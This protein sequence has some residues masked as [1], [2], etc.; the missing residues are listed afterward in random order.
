M[1]QML[2][3]RKKM[4]SSL[5]KH[6]NGS[7]GKAQLGRMMSKRASRRSHPPG[8]DVTPMPVADLAG[9]AHA[10]LVE[11]GGLH[12]ACEPRADGVPVAE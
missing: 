12:A 10:I 7:H 11:E 3:N 1:A 9:H 2:P 8:L 5:H 6:G 4:A